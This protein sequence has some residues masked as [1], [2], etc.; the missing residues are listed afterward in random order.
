MKTVKFKYDMHQKVVTPFDA[1]GIIGMLGFDSD[2][3]QYWIKTSTSDNWFR[4]SD[5]K[6]YKEK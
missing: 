3:V 6:P 5:I 2:G 1:V 4:E